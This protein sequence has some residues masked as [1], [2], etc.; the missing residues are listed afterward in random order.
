[1]GIAI[2]SEPK[3]TAALSSDDTFYRPFT[4]SFN[5]EL[6]G[7]IVR[8]LYVRN[9][10]PTRYY[11]DIQIVAV[12]SESP[13]RVTNAKSGWNWKMVEK[14]IAPVE[15][16]WPDVAA[17][18]TLIL[19]SDLGSTSMGDSATYLSFWVRVEIPPNQLVD[20]IKDIVLRLT[21]TEIL[22]GT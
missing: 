2:Y 5:G 1:M 14:D 13:S 18:N 21:A 11:E 15:E 12:D 19:S 9:D 16:E 20:N 6:G 17:G 3:P 7:N 4:V 22:V 10:D 8:R